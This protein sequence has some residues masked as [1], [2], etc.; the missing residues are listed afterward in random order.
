VEVIAVLDLGAV[1]VAELFE[2]S[3][4]SRAT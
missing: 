2:E 3:A 4:T 1:G